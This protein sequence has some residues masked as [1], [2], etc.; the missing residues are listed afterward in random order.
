MMKGG[1]FQPCVAGAALCERWR[2]LQ[3]CAHVRARARALPASIPAAYLSSSVDPAPETPAVHKPQGQRRSHLLL[4]RLVGPGDRPEAGGRLH[5]GL[6]R[7]AA[8]AAARG[9]ARRPAQRGGAG[10]AAGQ[11]PKPIEVD[12]HLGVRINNNDG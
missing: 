9:G 4:L 7:G 12:C 6:R 11:L 8:H 5:L 10:R 1:R 3:I 2:G